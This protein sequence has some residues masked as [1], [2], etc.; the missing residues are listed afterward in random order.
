MLES[1]P[2]I[3]LLS[4]LL[5]FLSGL[6]IGGGSL[7]ILWLTLALDMEPMAAR[8]INLLFFLPSALIAALFRWKQ[9]SV[10]FRRIYPAMLS[11]CAAA[12]AFSLLSANIHIHA[13]KKCFGVLLIATGIREIFY[14]PKQKREGP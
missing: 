14:T 13:L 12:L 3:L 9:G 7:L 2:F 1:I 8:G 10:P 5:G 6:G 4:T 11:G